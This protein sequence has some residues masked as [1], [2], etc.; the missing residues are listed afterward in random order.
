MEPVINL[1]IL[2]DGTNNLAFGGA[3]KEQPEGRI[4]S[5][6]AA[7]DTQT[8]RKQANGNGLGIPSFG[9][10]AVQIDS[11]VIE[12]GQL[13]FRDVPR[14]RVERLDNVNGKFRLASLNG[15]MEIDGNALIRKI[16][17]SFSASVG[18]IVQ[19]RTLPLRVAAKVIPGDVNLSYTGAISNLR[20]TPC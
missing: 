10:F 19:D 5:S 17:I 20:E 13:T 11:F 1:E 3:K 16:P 18:Q 8:A 7:T 12:N 14:G 6:V 9:G 4:S 2:E 15:P